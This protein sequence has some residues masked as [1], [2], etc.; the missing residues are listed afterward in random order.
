MA[1]EAQAIE[2][3]SNY[4]K[5]R[6]LELTKR[7]EY[8]P[9]SK[10]GKAWKS[11][12]PTVRNGII[13]VASAGAVF[14]IYKGVTAY[15]HWLETKGS[16][17]EIGKMNKALRDLAKKGVSPSY[18]DSQYKTWANQLQEAFDGC[19]TTTPV[20]MDILGRLNND[21]D[22]LKLSQAFGVGTFDKCGLGTGD[23]SGSLSKS[24]T[25][26]LGSDVSKANELF[27]KHGFNKRF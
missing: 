25:Y 27:R 4:G 21:A 15:M 11:V 26:K 20:V 18:D 3:L 10:F 7:T 17:E 24:I 6:E 22:F 16:R 8:N 23:Y 12:H 14:G 19:G 2:A 5:T 1:G 13:V 9:T